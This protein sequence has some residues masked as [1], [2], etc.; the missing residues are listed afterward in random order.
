MAMTIV[1]NPS[2]M[3]TLGELNKNVS[4]LG[5]QLKKVSSGMRINS[6]GDDASGYVISE[7][8]RVRIR[9]LD[10]DER[11]VQNGSALLRTAEGAI[12][13]QIEL[14]KTVKEKV[15]DAANDTNTDID[16]ATLQKEIDHAYEQIENI[17]QETNYNGKRLL[18]GD[19]VDEVVESWIVKA[20]SE[21]VEGSD[22]MN[23]VPN[24]YDTL[25]GATGPFDVFQSSKVRGVSA[26][27]YVLGFSPSIKFEGGVNG[28]SSTYTYTYT[29]G[30]GYASAADMDGTAFYVGGAY[31]LLTT[32]PDSS[33]EY[34]YISTSGGQTYK[35][36]YTVTQIDLSGCS[37]VADVMAL[38]DSKSG[39][40]T[41]HTANSFTSGSSISSVTFTASSGTTTG[42]ET[43]ASAGSGVF[44][45]GTNSTGIQDD[46]PDTPPFVPAT[47][48]TFT[49]SGLAAD[50]GIRLNNNYN[51][52]KFVPSS[53][54]LTYANGIYSVG[55]DYS[56]TFTFGGCT[57]TMGG[58]SLT[59]AAPITTDAMGNQNGV[60]GNS[61]QVLGGIP[62]D[63]PVEY[64]FSAA[65][66]L[67]GSS[68]Y[69]YTAGTP[70]VTATATVDVS[71]YTG[72]EDLIADLTGKAITLGTSSYGNNNYFETQGYPY[73]SS[74]NYYT[75]YEFI[76]SASG[77][78]VD[79]MYKIYGSKV[80]DLNTLRAGVEGGKT[81]AKAFSDLF[82]PQ[83]GRITE[84]KNDSDEVIG[85]KVSAY[86]S[87]TSGNSEKLWL[88]E[89]NLRS[90]ELDYGAWFAANPGA[91]IPGDLDDKGFRFYCATDAGQWF[92][93]HFNAGNQPDDV[94]PEHD[95]DAEDIKS[96]FIDVSEVTDAASLV[97]AIKTQ[98][99]EYLL[100][101]DPDFNHHYRM[102]ADGDKLIIYDNRRNTD[103]YF[104]KVKD[105]SNRNLY[106]Y[107]TY[108]AK[109]ADGVQ[110]N[111]LK[112]K[113]NIYV[114]PIIIQDTDRAN[115]NIRLKV[116]QTTL[117]HL[118]GYK[119][120]N[121][122]PSDFNVLT[123][124]SRDA[125]LGMGK[126]EESEGYLDHALNYLTSANVLVGA[127]IMRLAQSEA[128]IVT[129]RESTTAS[130]STLR[131]ADMAKEMTEY[132]KANVLAQAAQS[133]LAQA[134]Q[135]SSAVLSL[136]Q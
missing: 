115:Q 50:T 91:S 1:N 52:L 35:N 135:N 105:A 86:Y 46:D 81:I 92:N 107:Q 47:P 34:G 93:I 73:D 55:V 114:K 10:Q 132:T 130:E 65:S 70:S 13:S 99:D 79:T 54:G 136:L 2:A 108:G 96:I 5:K 72:V 110:D 7:R 127:Q 18:V 62:A 128:N 37:T 6:V 59:F 68:S 11:N 48:A 26:E 9:S 104:Q 19:E 80:L 4:Q 41:G 97:Q 87:G 120:E 27:D 82:A 95:P 78:P 123:K 134:N 30:S 98:A 103:T 44:S 31:Y 76:D 69:T 42:R 83:N 17:A 64:D 51:A 38:I 126:P 28:T 85:V 77:N 32:S 8:M 122:A 58:R 121:M 117:D 14:M 20:S 49:L 125:L 102:I 101:D 12:Q 74:S 89:N 88:T 53:Q 112:D 57:A 60:N 131:D 56:G 33:R 118:F 45:G 22:A 124:E 84:A 36:K 40:V 67:S 100:G 116:P 75:H 94:R 111:V 25:D 113:R 15:L 90:Y 133:M 109:I 106:D 66:P 16:R 39:Y 63:P 61:Y 119:K 71:G 24:V 43:I 3:L 23:M 129:S 29:V 21:M